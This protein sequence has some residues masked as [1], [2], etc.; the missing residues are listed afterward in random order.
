MPETPLIPPACGRAR[1]PRGLAAIHLAV[2][3]FGLSGLLGKMLTT[4]PRVIVFCRALVAAV[5]LGSAL[6]AWRAFPRLKPGHW[7]FFAGSGAVLAI[8]WLTFF[9]AIQVS[10]VAIGL[11]SFSSFPLFVTLLEPVVF[12]ERL[13]AGDLVTCL[14]VMAGLALVAPDFDL[15]RRLT[16]GA[17]WGTLS[18]LTFAV[19][20]IL[21]RKCV[22]GL[23]PLAIGAGQN[24]VAAALLLPFAGAAACRLSP[25]EAI[26]LLALGL[27][28]TAC[29]HALFIRGLAT[30]RAQVAGVLTG[31][32]PVYGML[33]AWLFLRE[34]PPPRIL[35]GG[36]L[37]LGASLLTTRSARSPTPPER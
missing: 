31:L 15:S 4:P 17:A 12:R 22:Q 8:H 19:L 10:T 26:L 14:L 6:W 5:A 27:L 34:A 11:L 20:S 18:G 36:L 7:V 35:L 32:E 33:L 30:V 25:R 28:C 23:S 13:R 24:A 3:L 29:A 9:Q 21:N 2:F 37:I 16:Q 1:A